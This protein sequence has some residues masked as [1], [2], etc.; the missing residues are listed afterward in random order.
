MTKIK[1]CGIREETAL[2]ATIQSGADFMGLL[3]YPPSACY[4]PLE[5]AASLA[6]H[7]AGKIT[8]VGLFVDPDDALLEASLSAV[9]LDM[10]Q[11]HGHETPARVADI[12][13]KSGLS[14]MKAIPI[15]EASDLANVP[16]YEEIADWLLF[17]TKLLKTTAPPQ[18]GEDRGE[19]AA[20][21]YNYGGAGISFDWNILKDKTF[22]KPWMLAGGLNAGNIVHAL[23]IL[24]PDGVDISSGVESTRGRK[25][26]AKIHA[27]IDAMRAIG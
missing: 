20:K 3:F 17:D 13:Q 11:L 9:T 6:K 7:A 27:F 19:A 8:R 24:K 10:I 25:D 26:L 5:T 12:K 4:V 2:D 1:I 21:S 16:L 22:K 23:S 15:A 14:V 18:G